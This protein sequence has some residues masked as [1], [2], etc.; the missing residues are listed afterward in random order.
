MPPRLWHCPKCGRPF[1]NRNQSHSCGKYGVRERLRGKTAHARALYRKGVETVRRC[2]PIHVAPTRTR[3]GF[4]A[5]VIF[6][7]VNKIGGE[8][9]HQVTGF[10]VNSRCS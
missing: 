3:I 1:A 4:Q 2:G 6:A 5:R 7:A 10:Y 9:K 8:Q